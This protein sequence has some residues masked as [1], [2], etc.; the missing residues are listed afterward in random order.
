M[1]NIVANQGGPWHGE[2][3]T[4][5]NRWGRI[6]QVVL[7]KRISIVMFSIMIVI[8]ISSIISSSRSSSSSSSFMVVI[9]ICYEY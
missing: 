8:V 5:Q 1:V 9:S 3:R 4:K 7:D 2:Y 6:R